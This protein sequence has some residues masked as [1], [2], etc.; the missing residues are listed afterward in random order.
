MPD[1]RE[2]TVSGNS[3]TRA[4][5]VV[6][7]NLKDQIPSAEF[8]EENVYILDGETI[9][10]NIGSLFVEMNDPNYIF[11]VKNPLTGE[12]IPDMYSTYGQIFTLL[13]SAYWDAAM[14]RD[15]ANE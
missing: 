10:K 11:Q 3:Y 14:K 4:K 12:D 13:Y 5:I 7:Q 8:V 9:H 15:R 1:Y 2:N 6:L